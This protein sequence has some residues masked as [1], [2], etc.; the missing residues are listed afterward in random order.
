M[1]VAATGLLLFGF[2]PIFVDD[3]QAV[4]GV[5]YS[6]IVSILV[7]AADLALACITLLK[8]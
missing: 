2:N 5:P 8:S 1:A 7:I 4:T 6:Q 3:T